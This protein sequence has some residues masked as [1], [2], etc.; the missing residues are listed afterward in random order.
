MQFQIF[1]MACSLTAVVIVTF[2]FADAQAA[3]L[4]ELSE[5]E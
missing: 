4:D 2:E 3:L 5:A 1:T